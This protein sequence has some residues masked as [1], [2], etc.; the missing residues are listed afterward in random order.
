MGTTDRNLKTS[1]QRPM[2]T[3]S[4][5]QGEMTVGQLLS[6]KQG[7]IMTAIGNA[8]PKHC[9]P[10]RMFQAAITATK[11]TPKLN[12]CNAAS[13]V[14]C[15]VRLSQYGLRLDGREAHMIPYGKEAT[16]IIDYKG[17]VKMAY[18]SGKVRNI[19]CGTVYEGDLFDYASCN[20]VPWHWLDEALRSRE[21]GKIKGAFCIVE[22]TT[23]GVHRERLTDIEVNGIRARSK[24]GS[25]G[26]WVT[27]FD[28]MAKKTAF[29][30]ATKWIPISD[31][32]ADAMATDDDRF[33]PLEAM[34]RPVASPQGVSGLESRIQALAAPE[35]AP[36]PMSA[37]P[38]A[39]E[40]AA[41]EAE[42][43]APSE[44]EQ[45]DLVKA[46][47]EELEDIDRDFHPDES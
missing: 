29:R 46:Q 19:E 35:P 21:R 31:E 14:N 37:G 22:L 32:L 25:S 30:R 38:S 12:A 9:T 20:H 8:A 42:T 3:R 11:L 18:Q 45:R 43:L 28:E 34:A 33:T 17:Y 13:F 40:A 27:D 7:E 44:E 23:G 6:M 5:P 2:T 10:E 24:A 15:L 36:L 1:G 47:N 39:L 4:K 41:E 26:P 16:L